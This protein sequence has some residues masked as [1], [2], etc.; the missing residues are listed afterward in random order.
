MSLMNMALQEN[1]KDY[2]LTWENITGLGEFID[3]KTFKANGLSNGTAYIFR[4]RQSN[5]YGWSDL[6]AASEPMS[7][8]G[9]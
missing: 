3:A 1:E 6:S 2:T 7:T 9:I 5:R 4:V 8:G